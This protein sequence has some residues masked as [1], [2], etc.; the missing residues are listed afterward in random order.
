MRKILISILVIISLGYIIYTLYISSRSESLQTLVQGLDIKIDA[1][2]NAQLFMSPRDVASEL[3]VRGLDVTGRRIDSLDIKHIERSL[4]ENPIFSSVQVYMSPQSNRLK[5]RVRQREA[6]FIVYLNSSPY[7][8]TRERGIIPLNHDYAVQVPV[9]TGSIDEDLAVGRLYDLHQSI[10]QD[11][12]FA[13]YFGHY[14]VDAQR[15]FILQPRIAD[16]YVILGFD[17]RWQEK[18]DKLRAFDQ[19]VITRRGWGGIEYINLSFL[20]QVI[21]KEHAHDR[22]LILE[23]TDNVKEL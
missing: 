3:K 14:Y 21:V 4:L 7:Y 13:G 9:V 15:G 2:A 8:V 22:L 10:I 12:Y 23:G 6:A 5:I 18:L 16:G 20:D 19:E 11:S 1:D 17:G